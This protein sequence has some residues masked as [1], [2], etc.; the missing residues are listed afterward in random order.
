[1]LSR[2]ETIVL[3][4]LRG[5]RVDIETDITNGLPYFTVIGFGDTAVK[6]ASDR[7][8][9]AII[10]SGFKYPKGRI[11]VNLSPAYIHKKGSHYDLG[12]A[13]AI[14]MA[15]GEIE[16]VRKGGL[17]I[18]ELALDGRVLAV[19][20]ALPMIMTA[21]E[22][23]KNEKADVKS[24]GKIKEILLPEENCAE[25]CLAA[26]QAGINLIPVRT[27]EEAA[28]Y[29]AGGYIER[30][31]G[32]SAAAETA[33]PDFAD[34]KGHRA[35]KAA[36][37]TAMAGAHSLLMVGAPGAGKT[38]L[39]RRAPGLLPPMSFREQLES[40]AVYSA[41]GLLGEDMPVIRNRPFRQISGTIT[42]AQLIGGGNVPSPGE[43]S[44]AHR[45]VLFADEMLEIPGNTLEALREPME[46]KQVRLVRRGT[47]HVFPADFL[48][49]GAANPCRCGFLGDP[50]HRCTC[51]QTEIEKY[52][53]KLSGPLADR[54]DM[55]IEIQRAD[56]GELE[57]ENTQSTEEL[58]SMVAAAVKIQEKRFKNRGFSRNSR[59]SEKDAEEFC[60]LNK[61]CKRFIGRIYDSFGMSPRRY[62]K[63]LKL[64]RTVADME[65]KEEIE[66][67]HLASS[68]QY[69]RILTEERIF[70]RRQE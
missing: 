39:A 25:A 11:T 19:K 62:N 48:F 21:A 24:G 16:S 29:M 51:S 13:L 10:N 47:V 68:F 40:S 31:K 14:L 45:G 46:E 44:F 4:G 3:Q 8:K 41:A 58:R 59:M 35:A 32:V 57:G 53:S 33:F 27:L 54:I 7:V 50:L 42:K 28:S 30:Y 34:V 1:M 36:I 55:C 66:E 6:E 2:T 61:E 17:L 64:A 43:A 12:I 5:R 52:R 65:G 63:I 18:G 67:E 23:R 60:N 20:G 49:I 15:S 69:T 38:M 37:A 22:D 56:Y 70:S 9:R 26:G